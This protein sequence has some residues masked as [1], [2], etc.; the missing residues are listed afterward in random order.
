MSQIRS[1]Y[2]VVLVWFGIRILSAHSVSQQDNIRSHFGSSVRV[3]EL[4]FLLRILFDVS[5]GTSMA[6][7]FVK[8]PPHGFVDN[9]VHMLRLG[10]A[11]GV[12]VPEVRPCHVEYGWTQSSLS[13][14][15]AGCSMHSLCGGAFLCH[16]LLSGWR[17][18]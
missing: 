6:G 14:H 18:H 3:G 17:W 5:A 2:S 8:A 4:W 12:V 1:E 13:F 16:N 11:A 9:E 7:T 10:A 15:A